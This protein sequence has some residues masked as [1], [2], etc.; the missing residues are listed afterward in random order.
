MEWKLQITLLLLCGIAHTHMV[1]GLNTV[2]PFSIKYSVHGCIALYWLVEQ[3]ELLFCQE[4]FAQG[5]SRGD[6]YVIIFL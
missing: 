2:Q 5:E 4:V 6:C 1:C 3:L